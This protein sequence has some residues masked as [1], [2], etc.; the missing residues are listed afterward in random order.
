[1]LDWP[2]FVSELEAYK[3]RFSSG[4]S[5]SEQELDYLRC[6]RSFE[7]HDSTARSARVRYLV[8]FLNGWECRLLDQT[9]QQK[10][11]AWIL[12]HAERLDAL[13][14]MSIY[15]ASFPEQLDEI[16]A[17]YD[18][19]MQLREPRPGLHNW[20]DACASKTWASSLHRRS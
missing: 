20:S 12:A 1:M 19:I 14:T 2:R 11:R 10:L 6:L 3:E 16:V 5:V 18:D 17:L 7:G 9:A 8:K 13:Q 15:A 4:G